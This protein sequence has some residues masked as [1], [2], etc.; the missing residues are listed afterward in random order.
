MSSHLWLVGMMGSGKSLIGPGLAE[1]LRLSFVD[2]D[3]AMAA[4]MG[5]SI[6][7]FWGERGEAAFRSMEAVAISEISA[8]PPAVVATGGGAVLQDTNVVAMRGS[9]RIV[10]LRA[11]VETLASRVGSGSGRPLL[12]GD[13]SVD[14]LAEILESRRHQYTSAADV[15]IDTDDVDPEE[16]IDRIEAWWNE[17]T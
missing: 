9:G 6:A 16:S 1:R 13:A 7:Q 10:W 12:A 14:R 17:S 2:T 8:G 11:A 3:E 5:C 15:I 4:R